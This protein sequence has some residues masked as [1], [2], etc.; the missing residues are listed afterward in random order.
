MS[1]GDAGTGEI[2]VFGS[3]NA[4]LTVRVERFP[5]PGETLGG[6]ELVTAPGGKSSNQAAA[7]AVLGSSVRLVGAVGDD[8]HGSFLLQQA[9]DAGVDTSGVI[10]DEE[11][12]TG[13][14][15]IVVDAA[16]EN[17]IIV[18]PGANG[19]HQ[20]ETAR[21]T[22]LEGAAVLCLCLEVPLA[23]VEAVAE[24]ARSS[25]TQ[26]ILNLSPYTS[27]SDSLLQATDVLLV[28]QSEA[29]LLLDAEV[30]GDWSAALERL[31]D[32]GVERTVVTLGADGAVVL[33]GT[34]EAP[35]QVVAIDSPAVDA[36]DTTGC[37][38]AF[39]GA[40]AHALA[41]GSSLVE[42]SKLAARVGALAATREGAQSSYGA[43]ADLPPE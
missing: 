8:S 11:H 17:T 12:A 26:V 5:E 16:G 4:D 28:N 1:G 38:D 14:A 23:A 27:V 30:D 34:A 43:F 32:L 21:Q 9:R 40:V 2:V 29:E 10:Q 33:D 20:A 22:D 31:V 3:L 24:Q 18:S 15:M 36:V 13:S 19:G 25:G 7:A 35:E 39:T 41:T 37:G 6:S 42:A